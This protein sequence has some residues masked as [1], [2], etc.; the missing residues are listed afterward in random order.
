MYSSLGLKNTVCGVDF[1]PMDN[2]AAFCS[3]GPQRPVL[4]YKYDTSVA[5]QE[6]GVALGGDGGL[7]STRQP[8]P[9]PLKTFSTIEVGEASKD[10]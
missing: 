3:F 4:V 6:A 7:M 8:P 9:S 10:G 2:Y 5:Q 1:H